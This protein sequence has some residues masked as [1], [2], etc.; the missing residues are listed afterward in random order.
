MIEPKK[1]IYTILSE[2][3]TNVYQARPEVAI[4]YPCIVFF[5]SS[6]VPKYVLGKEIG[7]QDMEV[8]VDIYAKTSIESGELLSTLESK[9]L[10]NNYRLV[11]NEDIPNDDSSH[12]TTR[13]NLVG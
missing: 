7:Y 13:F 5:V 12:I 2:V 6:N 1:D 4:E 8:T 10:E 9:M 3:T 11:F